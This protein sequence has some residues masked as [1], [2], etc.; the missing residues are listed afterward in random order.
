MHSPTPQTD[1]RAPTCW[2]APSAT[3]LGHV[4]LGEQSSVW[5]GAVLRGDTSEISIGDGSNVQDLACLHC[6]PG[7]PCVIEERV[8]IG[9]GAIVHG[10]HVERDSLIGIRA[11]VLN[12]ARIGT[13]S[14][15]A[16]GALVPE[17]KIIPPGS[18][19]MGVPGKVVRPVTA[20]DR[21][22]IEHAAEHYIE[23]AA[24]YKQCE[25]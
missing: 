22:M 17:G 21:Q 7:F 1:L 20:E 23:N 9:H 14:I 2:I 15:V 13:G 11:V 6:D 10:A 12:G 8:T 3:V 4:T 19:V 18:M 25:Q 24:H 5:F 16:A